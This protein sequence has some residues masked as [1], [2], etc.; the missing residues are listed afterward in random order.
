MQS[1]T[2]VQLI[3]STEADVYQYSIPARAPT[4]SDYTKLSATNTG[5]VQ[6][7]VNRRRNWPRRSDCPTATTD[8]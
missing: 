4:C 1:D 7:Y 6:L 2:P 3:S 8:R 5:R